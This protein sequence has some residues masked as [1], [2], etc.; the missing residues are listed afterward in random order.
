MLPQFSAIVDKVSIVGGTTN[1]G[2][3]WR[4]HGNTDST[5]IDYPLSLHQ[6]VPELNPL[7]RMIN[8]CSCV[9]CIPSD[10]FHDPSFGR[11]WGT[12]GERGMCKRCEDTGAGR[13]NIPHYMFKR[14]LDALLRRLSKLYAYLIGNPDESGDRLM[15]NL[16]SLPRL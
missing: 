1:F 16:K 5:V 11:R 4:G 15:G 13:T 6:K 7:I 14:M 12:L 8:E 9:F 2:I 10:C 3:D